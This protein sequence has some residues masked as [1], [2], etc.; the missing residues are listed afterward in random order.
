MTSFTASL[1]RP[2]RP[3]GRLRPRNEISSKINFLNF[4]ARRV[5]VQRLTLSDSRVCVTVSLFRL[6]GAMKRLHRGSQMVHMTQLGIYNT[7]AGLNTAILVWTAL[8][9]GLKHGPGT[10]ITDVQ[11]VVK[12]VMSGTSV[13]TYSVPARVQPLTLTRPAPRQ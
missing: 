2:G 8:P 7:C 12:L 5:H 1:Q 10:C 13:T 9:D 11:I 6:C 3:P 4:H